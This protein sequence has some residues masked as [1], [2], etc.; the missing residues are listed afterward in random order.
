MLERA[1]SAATHHSMGPLEI[2]Q[3][4]VLRVCRMVREQKAAASAVDR[5]RSER[6]GSAR[7]RLRSAATQSVARHT[8]K[9]PASLD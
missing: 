7:E 1:R 2:E 5:E 9:L 4:I 3:D 6:T 8:P